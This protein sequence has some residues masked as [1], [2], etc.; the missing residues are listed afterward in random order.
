MPSHI[1]S[2]GAMA[3]IGW[4]ELLR[5]LGNDPHT[6]SIIIYMESVGEYVVQLNQ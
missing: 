6:D 2:M 4:P 3:D 1:V 5:F